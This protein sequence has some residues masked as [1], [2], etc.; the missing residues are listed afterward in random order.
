MLGRMGIL[1]P[2]TEPTALPAAIE[3]AVS[4]EGSD[5]RWGLPEIWWEGKAVARVEALVRDLMERAA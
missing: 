1:P 3:R 5:A 4:G 2:V